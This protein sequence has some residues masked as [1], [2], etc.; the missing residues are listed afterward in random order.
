MTN[1]DRFARPTYS[2]KHLDKFYDRIRLPQ[3]IRDKIRSSDFTPDL[4]TLQ[5]L[6][7]YT[8]TWIPFECLSLHY[9]K[10]KKI[11]I[12]PDYLYK[13]IVSDNNGRGGYCMENNTLFST[14][15]RSIGYTA[16]PV[17]CRV[18]SDT[19]EGKEL[20]TYYAWYAVSVAIPGYYPP[21]ITLLT[22]MQVTHGEHRP[23]KRHPLPSRRRIRRQWSSP[24]ITTHDGGW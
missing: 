11:T 16:Y 14:V 5:T 22:T 13:K 8:V 15:L 2:P 1:S 18:N 20:P 23:P 24:P 3:N 17:G 21:V 10:D 12:T 19:N 6:Q 9:S 7:L 4:D